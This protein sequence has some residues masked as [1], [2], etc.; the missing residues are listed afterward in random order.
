MRMA[1]H[2]PRFQRLVNLRHGEGR[3]GTK[4][5]LLAQLLLPL[6]DEN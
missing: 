6:A 4:H 5:H 1:F 2:A 3:V